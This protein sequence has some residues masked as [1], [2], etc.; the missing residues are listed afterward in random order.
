MKSRI[1]PVRTYVLIWAALMA[2]L[3]L[4]W[5]VAQIDLRPFNIVVALGIAFI[6]MILVILIFM[7]VRYEPRLTWIFVAAGFIWFAVMV[8]LTMTD[9]L[10]RPRP[11]INVRQGVGRAPER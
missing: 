5:G 10:T 6:K 7:H 9:Y 2:L 4:T 1:L 8:D 3:L 11:Q